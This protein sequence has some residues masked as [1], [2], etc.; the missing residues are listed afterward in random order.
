MYYT[1]NPRLTFDYLIFDPISVYNHGLTYM[2]FSC[3]KKKSLFIF[4]PLQM[5]FKKLIQVLP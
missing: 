3:A 1:L 5:I 2:S 4:Q